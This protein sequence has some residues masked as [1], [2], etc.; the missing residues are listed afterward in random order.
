MLLHVELIAFA[1]A[2][3]TAPCILT[4]AVWASTGQFFFA[5]ID[6]YFMSTQRELINK[7]CRGQHF[8]F[9]KLNKE[10][11]GMVVPSQL[12]TPSPLNPCGHLQPFE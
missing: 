8:S 11:T 3:V 9:R 5:L 6:I 4:F 7:F 12:L 2:L 1:A 10:N